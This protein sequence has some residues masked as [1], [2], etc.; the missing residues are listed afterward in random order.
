MKKIY[1]FL[2]LLVMT[3]MCVT[4]SAKTFTI[5]VDDRNHIGYAMLTSDYNHLTFTTDNKVEFEAETTDYLVISAASGYQLASVVDGENN[6]LAY[7]TPSETVQVELAALGDGN[8]IK[9]TTSEKEMK[10]FTFTGD[11][12]LTVSMYTWETGDVQYPAE[13]GVFTVPMPDN[14]YNPVTISSDIENLAI[15]KV[16][17]DNGHEHLPN[18]GTVSIYSSEYS[19][20]THFT[21]ETYNPDEARTASMTVKVNG[22][23]DNVVLSRSDNTVVTLNS[24]GETIVKFDPENETE[25]TIR[26][27]NYNKPIYQVKQNDERVDASYGTYYITVN[28]GDVLEITPDFPDVDVPVT[29]IFTNEGTQDVISYITVDNENIENW[30]EEDF[31]VKMGS[32]LYV[33]LNS[34][35][36]DITEWKVNDV[37]Q[38]S[39]S[40]SYSSTI[41][42]EEPLV[43]VITATKKASKNITVHCDEYENVVVY[44]FNQYYS[45][46]AS[47]ELIGKDTQ[48]EVS[49]AASYVQI[50]AVE[51]WIISYI[52]D[53]NGTVYDANSYILASEGLELF[54][55]AKAIERDRN[56]IV[57]VGGEE[58]DWTYRGI[59]L[60]SDNYDIRKEYSSYDETLPLGYT[61]IP[62][63]DFDCPIQ[64][65]GYVG[66]YYDNPIIYLNNEQ[67]VFNTSSWRYEGLD[68]ELQ[69]GDVLKM[70]PAE[71]ATYDVTYSIEAEVDVEVVHD[72][73]HAIA[74][75]A[76]VVHNV[77]EGTEVWIKAVDEIVVTVNGEDITANEEG[78]YT[79]AINEDATVKVISNIANG[80]LDLNAKVAGNADIYNLQGIRV[81]RVSDASRLPAGVY[82]INGQKVRF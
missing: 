49:A 40:Y 39:Y 8:E 34:D 51:D 19:E 1:A 52:E 9:V 26:S 13:N 71:P 28:D 31:S 42:S 20:S 75:D 25:F 22:S 56:L 61:N 64:V 59:T 53:A 18:Y 58:T 65:S 81:G 38:S 45:Q 76:A 30:K 79:F 11:E 23:A 43:F 21:I 37:T 32:Q 74:V 46:I 77:L 82:I 6:S 35:D 67:C 7:N 50:K 73:S 60:S 78:V 27:D 15:R 66:P 55:G 72:H 41:T 24:N 12:R 68:G 62:F 44:G 47:Y 16:V 2:M 69:D 3:A 5:T 63:G 36:Y 4:A 57:Y 80:I 70:F 48:I 17:A 10:V 14:G 33:R 54:V 29:F